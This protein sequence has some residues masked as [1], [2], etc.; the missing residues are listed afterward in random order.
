M[1]LGKLPQVKFPQKVDAVLTT[2]RCS[3]EMPSDRRG[4]Y[5]AVLNI[6]CL[7]FLFLLLFLKILF[8]LRT[9]WRCS[10][11]YTFITWKGMF[12]HC[13]INGL[14]SQLLCILVI[15]LGRQ[16][17]S[18]R[19]LFLWV[20][21]ISAISHLLVLHSNSLYASFSSLKPFWSLPLPSCAELMASFWYATALASI[22]P[23]SFFL[24]WSKYSSFF[25]SGEYN[26]L[27]FSDFTFVLYYLPWLI[28]TSPCHI[29][30]T[31]EFFI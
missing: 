23:T 12:E 15:Q 1:G 2:F 4:N 6:K 17:R 8:S 25:F 18:S 11:S 9:T 30:H 27:C 3:P 29:P 22:F 31:Y 28:C 21:S 13:F 19:C 7:T 20:H 14:R 5:L 24:S 10:K 16:S 26:H